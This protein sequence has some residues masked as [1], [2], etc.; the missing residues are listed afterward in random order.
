MEGSDRLKAL[1]I[2]VFIIQP[3]LAV[4][5]KV[6]MVALVLRKANALIWKSIFHHFLMTEKV[7]KMGCS[8]PHGTRQRMFKSWWFCPRKWA[9]LTEVFIGIGRQD[10]SV[11]ADE[12]RAWC[13]PWVPS[14]VDTLT[15]SPRRQLETLKSNSSSAFQKYVARTGQWNK[16]ILNVWKSCS[17]SPCTLL[18]RKDS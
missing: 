13:W 16:N 10:P 11:W 9:L 8:V 15:V 4:S 6:A 7:T 18:C 5:A 1:I 3:K 2:Q 17:Q 12:I 14:W